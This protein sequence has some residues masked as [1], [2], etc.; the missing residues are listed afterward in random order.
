MAWSYYRISTYLLLILSAN[1]FHII[2]DTYCEYLIY[3]RLLIFFSHGFDIECKCISYSMIPVDARTYGFVI[4]SYHSS[5]FF[6]YLWMRYIGIGNDCYYSSYSLDTCESIS[7]CTWY[8]WRT[9]FILPMIHNVSAFHT[10]HDT[11]C[12]CF[13]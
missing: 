6:C 11:Y 7:Y 13:I 2:V 1:A 3:C 10:A 8:L 9:P 12:D 4:N 5:Y